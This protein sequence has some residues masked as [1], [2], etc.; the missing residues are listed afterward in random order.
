MTMEE[1]KNQL[2]EVS[3]ILGSGKRALLLWIITQKPQGYSQIYKKF[4]EFEVVIGSSEVYKHIDNL[5]AHKMII[6][7]GKM[8]LITLRGKTLIEGL[9]KLS[10]VPHKVPHIEMVF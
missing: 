2:M 10:E 3:E 7:R 4:E 5:V 1:T 9:T 6:K 8:Y